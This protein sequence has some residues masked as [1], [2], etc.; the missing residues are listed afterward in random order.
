MNLFTFN[1]CY[2]VHLYVKH[3]F[4]VTFKVRNVRFSYAWQKLKLFYENDWLN[5]E[6]FPRQNSNESSPTSISITKDMFFKNLVLLLSFC[7]KLNPHYHK[8]N[9]TA[10][11]MEIP[12]RARVFGLL[13]KLIISSEESRVNGSTKK[14]ERYIQTNKTPGGVFAG[15]VGVNIFTF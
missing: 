8:E 9:H 1:R 11:Y 13:Q 14:V 6:R 3:N 15:W 10:S 2:V 5:S 4:S 12:F 7:E